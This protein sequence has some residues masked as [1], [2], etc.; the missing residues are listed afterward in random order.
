MPAASAPRSL[1]P[2]E[3]ALPETDE[4]RLMF[5]AEVL[6]ANVPSLIAD[7]SSAKY[8]FLSFSEKTRNEVKQKSALI[9]SIGRTFTSLKNAE[10]ALIAAQHTLQEYE[11]M[12][13]RAS[14]PTFVTSAEA[15]HLYEARADGGATSAAQNGSASPPSAAAAAP[16]SRRLLTASS[17]NLVILHEEDVRRVR[18]AEVAYEK[19]T[20]AYT[21]IAKVCNTMEDELEQA[22]EQCRA[23]TEHV[24]GLKWKYDEA[25]NGWKHAERERRILGVM[26]D[27]LKGRR[28][29]ITDALQGVKTI[30]GHCRAQESKIIEDSIA[31]AQ[32]EEEALRTELQAKRNRNELELAAYQIAFKEQQAEVES[33]REHCNLLRVH[34]RDLEI[35]AKKQQLEEMD[36]NS[37]RKLVMETLMLTA[38][39]HGHVEDRPLTAEQ[40]EQVRK[41]HP[42]VSLLAA[43]ISALEEQR[44]I[45]GGLLVQARGMGKGGDVSATID[46]IRTLLE[47]KV[48][49][50][51]DALMGD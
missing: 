43:R 27:E 7:L 41:D 34:Q 35:L 47:S 40:Q 3:A 49:L 4:A 5:Y 13:V 48:Q 18:E 1:P 30:G 32:A 12:L 25:Y 10:K 11:T 21:G 24:Q 9:Q 6:M 17:D 29:I 50:D 31:H 16:E 38:P 20:A 8:A 45:V 46:R 23:M 42:L 37:L 14:P 39:K 19:E 33:L 26:R 44:K 22:Q 28:A 2:A 15:L 51:E 36:R